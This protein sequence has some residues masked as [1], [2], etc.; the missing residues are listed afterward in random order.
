MYLHRT[1]G[2]WGPVLFPLAAGAY[3]SVY[4]LF[5]TQHRSSSEA[6]AVGNLVAIV[7][8]DSVPLQAKD[9][10]HWGFHGG[11]YEECRL[12][13]YKNPVRTSQETHYVSTTELSW[14]MLSKIWGFHGGDY[15]EFRLLGYK[16]PVRTS[17]ETHYVSTTKSSQLMLCKIW[18]F[19]GSDWRMRS[20]GML[21]HE[22][23]VITDV[24]EELRASIIRVTKSV[25]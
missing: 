7:T 15:E 21:R 12:L 4:F 19:Y 20:S 8:V 1:V 2:F 17:Q 25:N 6:C 5:H 9:I 3:I 10:Q 16:N 14:L 11:D 18:G 22:A 13:G 23:L 24:S